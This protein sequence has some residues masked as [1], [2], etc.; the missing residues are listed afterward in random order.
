MKLSELITQAQA[1]HD[2]LGDLEVWVSTKYCTGEQGIATVLEY[3]ANIEPE[4]DDDDGVD[5]GPV[6]VLIAD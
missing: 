5:S 1:L 6:I 4:S 2:E 3:E